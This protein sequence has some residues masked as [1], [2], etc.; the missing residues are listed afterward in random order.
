MRQGIGKLRDAMDARVGGQIDQQ[1]VE[2]PAELAAWLYDRLVGPLPTPARSA[3]ELILVPDGVLQLVPFDALID[4]RP[5]PH[6]LIDDHI[7]SVATSLEEAPLLGRVNPEGIVVVAPDADTSSDVSIESRAVAAAMRDHHPVLLAG[8]AAT[9]QNVRAR[10]GSAGIVHFAT[11][12][13]ANEHDPNSSALAL[14]ARSPDDG[15]LHAFEVDR[16]DVRAHLV[17]LDACETARGRL[18]E[19]EGVLSLSR[20]FLRA[21]AQATVATLWP[22]GPSSV[23]F[24]RELY[25]ALAD[26]A[27]PAGAVHAAKLALRKRGASPFLW[28]PYVLVRRGVSSGNSANS[29]SVRL[30]PSSSSS[31]FLRGNPPP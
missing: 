29:G 30:R 23:P 31:F 11:H 17:V 6:Y 15:R 13:V 12:A 4:R 19:G 14:R 20:S 1:R 10:L 28:A 26:G 8:S 25:A 18:L 5:A 9:E 7:V 16:I 22:V 21:G 2:F 3:T 27:S 24:A